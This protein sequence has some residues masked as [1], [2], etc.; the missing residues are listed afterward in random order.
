MISF[1]L[2]PEQAQWRQKARDFAQERIAPLSWGLDR[3]SHEEFPWPLI[4]E[5][6]QE[7]LLNLGVPTQYGGS[8]LD[9]LTS[10]LVIEELAVADPGI[11]FTVTL[12][13][14]VPLMIA[15][16]PEQQEK[17]FPLTCDK[18]NPG[19]SAFALTE[20]N[21]GSDAGAASA[22][23]RKEG[24]EYVLNGEKCFISNGDQAALYAIFAT[25]DRSA[26]LKAM[27]AFLVPGDSPGLSRG[28]FEDKMGFRSSHTGV[29]AMQDVR[30]PASNLLGQEGGG[31]KI[32]MQ[33]L[34]VLR[35]ISCG[36]VGVG[37]ARAATEKSLEFLKDHSEPKKLPNQ[38]ALTFPLAEMQA[39][40]E[41]A[42]LMVWKT[43]WMLDSKV[44][45]GTMSGL[46]KFYA[47]DAALQVAEKGLQLTGPHGRTGQYP[48][49]KLVRD[50][51]LL[52]IYEGTNQIS[53]LVAS[54]G[55]LAG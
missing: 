25:L 26:G 31:F 43:A 33:T 23:A 17:F 14:Y 44:P 28:K 36:A 15:G 34:E 41:A 22:T 24:D 20:P 39:S 54:R 49:E 27:T 38:Q 21:A 37:L 35:I 13:S 6:N 10:C 2:T 46:T 11:A 40:V 51:K 48:L 53:R 5:L 12:N 32:A 8:G 9:I 7:G 29:F 19:L 18:D 47:S 3:S 16:T 55:I 1:E 42:R 50:A 45:A 4:R 52:Q 30:I